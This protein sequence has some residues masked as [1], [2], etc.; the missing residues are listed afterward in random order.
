L[1]FDSAGAA[2]SQSVR[3]DT[4]Q[5]RTYHYWHTFVEDVGAGQ[6]YGYRAH[7][8]N[9]PEQGLRFD[10]S[11]V[12]IDP[13]TF[14]T[15]NNEN[16]RRDKASQAG[17]NT[18]YALKS[19]VVDPAAYNWEGDTP[20]RRRLWMQSSTRCTSAGLLATKFA[21]RSGQ[22]RTYAGLIEKSLTYK[23][24]NL[25]VEQCPYN[26]SMRKPPC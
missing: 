10:P 18:A 20:I 7:G 26:N 22:A 8:P 16:Y 2:T 25:A 24:W 4:V 23:N 6:L 12:L 15:A 11:K 13:Y 14:E 5:N 21:R 9:A 17:D 1:L 19:V 3:L